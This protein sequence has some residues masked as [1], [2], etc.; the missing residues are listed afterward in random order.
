[1]NKKTA[2][3]IVYKDGCVLLIKK[4][5][6]WDLPKGKIEKNHTRRET[7]IQEIHEET[8]VPK[9]SLEITCKLAPTKYLKIINGET[10]I[11]HTTWYAVKFH[12]NLDDVLIP[13]SHE[14]ITKCKWVLINKLDSKMNKSFPHIIYIINYYLSLMKNDLIT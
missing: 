10:I 6:K 3:G 8:G 12:G 5:K 13:D 9:N 14:G 4:N 11:K 1:M 7:A 2:G